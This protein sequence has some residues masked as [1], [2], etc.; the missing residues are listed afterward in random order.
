MQKI[1]QTSGLGEETYMPPS[2]ISLC[3]WTRKCVT[4]SPCKTTYKYLEQDSQGSYSS[5]DVL[6]GHGVK[7]LC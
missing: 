6:A 7:L 3:C 4:M 2:A 1:L 5:A